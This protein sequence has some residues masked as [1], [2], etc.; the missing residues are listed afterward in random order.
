MKYPQLEL[1]PSIRI[2]GR[3]RSRL[4]SDPQM[5]DDCWDTL[6]EAPLQTLTAQVESDDEQPSNAQLSEIARGSEEEEEETNEHT[7]N[8]NR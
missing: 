2:Q 5:S 4:V 8:E 7:P 3:K 6:R 1:H